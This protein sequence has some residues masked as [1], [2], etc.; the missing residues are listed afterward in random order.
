MAVSALPAAKTSPAGGDFLF[1]HMND[2]NFMF[3]APVHAFEKGVRQ[4]E[5]IALHL[6]APV[7]NKNF[8][9]NF[10]TSPESLTRAAGFRPRA[11]RKGESLI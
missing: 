1:P 6:G 7:Q 9:I 4:A 11:N 3:T 5:S 2:V 10:L 8:H